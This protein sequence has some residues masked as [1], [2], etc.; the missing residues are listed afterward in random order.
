VTSCAGCGA[1]VSAT[2]SHMG[3]SGQCAACFKERW[4]V[5]PL[6][7]ELVKQEDEPT[8][9]RTEEDEGP[10]SQPED[11]RPDRDFEGGF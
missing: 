10:T 11:P 9:H 7:S 4:G 1:D 2:Y 8:H 3:E 5:N 6:P